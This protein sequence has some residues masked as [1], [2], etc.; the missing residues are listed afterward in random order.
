MIVG[1]SFKNFNAVRRHSDIFVFIN[2]TKINN[3][4]FSLEPPQL[5]FDRG[6]VDFD[7]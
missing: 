4:R 7:R 2:I 3:E 1:Y 5:T 6:V